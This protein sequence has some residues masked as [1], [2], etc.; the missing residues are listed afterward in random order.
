M[1]RNRE[2][3]PEERNYTVQCKC[4]MCNSTTEVKVRYGDYL[5]RFA[6]R[7]PAQNCFPYLSVPERESIISGTCPD[8]QKKIWRNNYDNNGNWVGAR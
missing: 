8:C 3:R 2:I 4:S 1:K 5:L 7:K 6:M